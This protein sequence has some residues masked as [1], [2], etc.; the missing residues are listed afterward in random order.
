MSFLMIILPMVSADYLDGTSY[1]GTSAMF[2]QE[3]LPRNNIYDNSLI[4]SSKW[5]SARGGKTNKTY[6]FYSNFPCY[7]IS[8]DYISN[9]SD[10]RSLLN[11]PPSSTVGGNISNAF[12]NYTVSSWGE[13]TMSEGWYVLGY[14][15]NGTMKYGIFN[16]SRSAKI[17]MYGAENNSY[18]D[19][20]AGQGI[21]ELTPA[22]TNIT[23]WGCV[24]T[25]INYGIAQNMSKALMSPISFTYGAEQSAT[26]SNTCTYSGSGNWAVACSDNC[27]I[28]SNVN[29]N[30]NS[31][32][33][34]GTG[35]FLLKANI[36]N[37]KY[38]TFWGNSANAQCNV[39]C[40]GGN[41][42]QS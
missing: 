13:Q 25:G 7:L 15:G 10:W 4:W 35:Q 30:G 11:A 32:T 16:A 40:L 5:A 8:F 26:P 3:N 27:T 28:S 39:Y 19:T 22:M 37:V 12:A 42:F 23:F 17:H 41:C 31:M 33:I 29:L 2:Y 21:R 24:G 36:T 34:N 38:K 14:W 6:T 18:G 1:T 9:N 20:Y